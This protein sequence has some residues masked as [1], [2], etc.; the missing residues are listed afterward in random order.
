MAPSSAAG[1]VLSVGDVRIFRVEELILPTSARW[2][3]PDVTR[4][5]VEP[6]KTWLQ[7]HFM[8]E[9][10]YLL[11][12]I[13]TYVVKTPIQVI[14]VDTGVGNAKQRGGGI[15]AFNMLDTPFLDR[16]ASI[17]VT[18]TEVDLVLCTHMHGDH[19]GWNTNLVNDV[20]TPTFPKARYL[21][22]EKEFTYWNATSETAGGTRQLMVDSVQP[23]FEADQV[24]L[25]PT[26]Y[27]VSPEIELEPSHGHTPGHVNI[28]IESKGQ[29]AVLIGDVMHNPIQCAFPHLK[30]SLGGNEEPSR[31]A[32]LAMLR[33]YADTDTLVLGAHFNAPC[34]GRVYR[35]GETFRFEAL[36]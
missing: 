6:T 9:A 16:L 33:R 20:W 27:V 19:V 23:V 1:L 21:F 26:D 28:R 31:E 24:D 7:P 11:Q 14:L 36:V 15:P 17:D 2:L 35:D 34:A 25:V 13:H 4:P 10:G 8:N 22:C 29:S 30:S 12:S 5:E 18:P 32:R 3:L